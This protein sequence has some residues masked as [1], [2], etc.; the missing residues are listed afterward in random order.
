MSRELEAAVVVGLLWTVGCSSALPR[1]RAREVAIQPPESEE[2][3]PA[4]DASNRATR[5]GRGETAPG[6]LPAG[7]DEPETAEQAFADLLESMGVRFLRD[8]KSLEIEGRVN[9][10]K[11]LVEV[12]ACA[13]DGKAHESVIVLDCVPSAVHAGL[14]ALGLTPGTPVE[15]G[16]AAD[17]RPPTGD[18]VEVTVRWTGPRGEEITAR[19]EDWIWNEKEGRSMAHC[20]WVFAGSFMQSATGDSEDL[21]YAANYVKSIVTTYHDPSSIL[22]NPFPDGRDDTVYYANEKA[23]PPVLTPVTAILRKAE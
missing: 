9:M 12:F 23:V 14:L 19:A 4:P 16:T 10:Q 3:P 17:Y 1:E 13:P 18:G 5:G 15:T 2:R 20:A 11:G 6:P 22:E 7:S 8:A 21:T